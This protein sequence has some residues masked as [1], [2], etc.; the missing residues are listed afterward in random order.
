MQKRSFLCPKE[1]QLV[2]AIADRKL[3]YNKRQPSLR[4]EG[5]LLVI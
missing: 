4:T 3:Q 5:K 1:K 2:Q